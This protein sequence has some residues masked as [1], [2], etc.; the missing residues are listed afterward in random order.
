MS[1]SCPSAST[2]RYHS[3][4]TPDRAADELSAVAAGAVFAAALSYLPA[5][6]RSS[7]TPDASARRRA[8]LARSPPARRPR[9]VP[10][11]ALICGARSTARSGDGAGRLRRARRRGAAARRSRGGAP[12]VLPRSGGARGVLV[13]GQ[14]VFVELPARPRPRAPR[15]RDRALA[16]RRGARRSPS[17]GPRGSSSPPTSPRSPSR[18]S[19]S[20]AAIARRG[21]RRPRPPQAAS[22]R[23]ARRLEVTD[24][25][26]ASRASSSSTSSPTLRRPATRSAPARRP[27]GALRQARRGLRAPSRAGRPLRAARDRWRHPV[28]HRRTSSAISAHMSRGRPAR[29]APPRDGARDLPRRAGAPRRGTRRVS[30]RSRA[31]LGVTRKSAPE[32][33]RLAP[34]RE[35]TPATPTLRRLRGR[36][37]AAQP[38]RPRPPLRLLRDGRG[39]PRASSSSAGR[40]RRAEGRP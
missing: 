40:S 4:V 23:T 38:L 33:D 29:D 10:A 16:P 35:R 22:P 24:S 12:L 37:D 36:V 19:R 6:A 15:A 3:P 32:T 28:R 30:G 34:V 2:F 1:A 27:P 31:Q 9:R 13:L 25:M 14:A 17:C 18:S 26:E 39:G 20:L 7:A 5:R 21:G 8:T 11:R